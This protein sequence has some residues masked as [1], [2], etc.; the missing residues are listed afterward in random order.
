MDQWAGMDLRVSFPAWGLKGV[1]WCVR[2]ILAGM[3]RG[4]NLLHLSLGRQMEFNADNV[5]VSVTGVGRA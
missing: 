4:L 5:A 2:G 1:L 3:Y